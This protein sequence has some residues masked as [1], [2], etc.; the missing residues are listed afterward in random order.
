MSDDN[1]AGTYPHADGYNAGLA[2][3]LYERSLREQGVVP[4]SL[5]DLIAGPSEASLR[6]ERQVDLA[7]VP[8]EQL[9]IAAAKRQRHAPDRL[10]VF[11]H[12]AAN[13]RNDFLLLPLHIIAP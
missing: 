3:E 11:R 4:P 12:R 6:P 7:L 2:E 1:G 9:R 13:L 5:A 10:P 8:P